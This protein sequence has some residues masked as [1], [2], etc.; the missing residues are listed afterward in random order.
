M[1]Y[2]EG[3]RSI[4]LSSEPLLIE[5]GREK[6]WILAVY[7]PR[8][9][10]WDESGEGLIE[11]SQ[12]QRIIERITDALRRKVGEFRILPAVS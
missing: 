3:N 4:T 12:E 6:R 8:Q 1:R 2:R 11:P 7:I 9:L 10:R 5:K